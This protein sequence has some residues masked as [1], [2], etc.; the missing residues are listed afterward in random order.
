MM[1]IHKVKGGGIIPAAL[2]RIRMS[3]VFPPGHPP[4]GVGSAAES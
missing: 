3:C 2:M 4:V 1:K